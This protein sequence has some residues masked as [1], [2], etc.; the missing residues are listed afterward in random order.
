MRTRTLSLAFLLFLLVLPLPTRAF[1][2]PQ[3]GRWLSRD[4]IGEKGGRNLFAL[5]HNDPVK[6]VDYLGLEFV[7][8]FPWALD[9]R[10]IK[11]G[12]DWAKEYGEK[13]DKLYDT[14]KKWIKENPCCAYAARNSR[15]ETTKTVKDRYGHLQGGSVANAILHCTWMCYVKSMVLCSKDDAQGLGNAHEEGAP[16]NAGTQDRAMDL[17]NNQVGLGIGGKNLGDCLSKCEAA[18]N[19]HQLYW[20]EPSPFPSPYSPSDFP[21]FRLG[22]N[23]G[24]IGGTPGGGSPNPP[25]WGGGLR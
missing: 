11:K 7:N 4:P 3:A 5:V 6:R 10:C 24:I 1:Y 8:P 13:W 9:C 2:N 12:F 22:E 20:F 23:G 21:A 17:F 14:E 15:E 19:A 18:A 25:V 16:G